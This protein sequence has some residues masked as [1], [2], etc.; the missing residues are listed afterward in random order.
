VIGAAFSK[1][2][3]NKVSAPIE[4]SNALFV[5]QVRQIGATSSMNA[6]INA[7]K[8]AVEAQLRQYANFSTMEA[9][10]KSA[11][12]EDNRSKVY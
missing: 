2:L 5:L 3:V 7:Q 1:S 6:D 12:I 10:R 9:L 8:K 4:G 11:K